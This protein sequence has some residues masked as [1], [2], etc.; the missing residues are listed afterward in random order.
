MFWRYVASH[1]GPIPWYAY[2]RLVTAA[3]NLSLGVWIL[4]RTRKNYQEIKKARQ[5][6]RDFQEAETEQIR[7]AAEARIRGYVEQTMRVHI[8]RARMREL[9]EAPTD[10]PT[11][12]NPEGILI[13]P[14][15]FNFF[16]YAAL[17]DTRT[18]EQKMNAKRKAKANLERVVTALKCKPVASPYEPAFSLT[19]KDGTRFI[20]DT[21]YIYRVGAVRAEQTCYQIAVMCPC[22]EKVATALLQLNRNPE[23]F[24]TLK[25]FQGTWVC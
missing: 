23:I 24:Y 5:A 7:L 1:P 21:S 6:M 11:A 10:A 17:V 18:T 12:A 13:D 8:E 9:R 3:V 16:E 22:E 19:A 2:L 14:R 20:V 4:Y 25:N 15:A